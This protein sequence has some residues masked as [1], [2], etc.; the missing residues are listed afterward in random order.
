MTNIVE[1]FSTTVCP[2]CSKLSEYLNKMGIKYV[3]R[4]IDTD[5]EAETD[6]CMLNI[7]AAPALR[8][9]DKVLRAKDLFIQDQIIEEKLKHFVQN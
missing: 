9:G 4:L 3:K 6:A 1:L 7:C 2:K 8:I 5:P